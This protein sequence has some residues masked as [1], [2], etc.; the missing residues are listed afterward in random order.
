MALLLYY[1]YIKYNQWG[2]LGEDHGTVL[3]LQLPVNL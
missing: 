2:K 1:A 3:F